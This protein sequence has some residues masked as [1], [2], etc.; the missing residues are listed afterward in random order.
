MAVLLV[1]ELVSAGFVSTEI[2]DSKYSVG[3]KKD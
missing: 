3:S 1:Y 2:P